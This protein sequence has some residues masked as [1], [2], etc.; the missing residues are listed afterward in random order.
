[1]VSLSSF[2]GAVHCAGDSMGGDIRTWWGDAWNEVQAAFLILI[3]GRMHHGGACRVLVWHTHTILRSAFSPWSCACGT[4]RWIM[5][6]EQLASASI[7]LLWYYAHYSRPPWF[8][9][10]SIILLLHVAISTD[11]STDQPCAL[12]MCATQPGVSHTGP[13]HVYL[14]AWC[15]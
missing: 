6:Q 7:A 11:R 1:M 8:E 2:P 14:G 13:T 9:V 12:D 10:M 5:Q 3:L 4:S 15:S